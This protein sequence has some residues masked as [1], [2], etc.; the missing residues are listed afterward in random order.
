MLALICFRLPHVDF[1]VR[2]ECVL[3]HPGQSALSEPHHRGERDFG[4][5]LLTVIQAPT[6]NMLTACKIFMRQALLD[7]IQLSALISFSTA[8]SMSHPGLFKA[9]LGI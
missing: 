8:A 9:H 2:H 1:K 4:T 3:Q 5:N 7:P 6:T